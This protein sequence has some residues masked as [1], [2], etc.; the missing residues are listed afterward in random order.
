MRRS[1]PVMIIATLVG[2]LAVLAAPLAA[3]EQSVVEPTWIVDTDY[4]TDGVTQLDDVYSEAQV[5][6]PS[7]RAY[8]LADRIGGSDLVSLIRFT[9]AGELD[10][11]FGEGGFVDLPIVGPLDHLSMALQRT[12]AGNRL[13]L[14]EWSVFGTASFFRYW[15]DGRLDQSF[16]L[17]GA[18]RIDLGRDMYIRDLTINDDG[19]II[20]AGE[21]PARPATYYPCILALTADGARDGTFDS[22]GFRVWKDAG[23]RTFVRSVLM[24]PD[25]SRIYLG[26]RAD[27]D[28]SWFIGALHAN[29][30]PDPYFG[31][32]GIV[33]LQPK[34]ADPSG[35]ITQLHLESSGRL[36]AAGGHCTHAGFARVTSDGQIDPEYGDDGWVTLD[37]G[38]TRPATVLDPTAETVYWLH[39]GDDDL[40]LGGVRSDG[41]F[42][43][44][45]GPTFELVIDLEPGV[46]SIFDL[47]LVR[48]RVGRL[49]PKG[50]Y[51]DDVD[52]S[53][54][55][56]SRAVQVGGG[57]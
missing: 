49:Y 34:C 16:G 43:P 37:H 22:D 3:A 29:G 46:P 33:R 52:F 31:G 11:G 47:G 2:S 45:F 54:L 44:A 53:G 36:V 50:W 7:G 51:R 5:V 28:A 17:G 15:K 26:G 55:I 30:K 57:D 23:R 41:S 38:D 9:A 48:D 14:S 25:G 18:A 4:G 20:T 12:S 1:R 21:C 13:V 42:D 40:H 6:L 24:T 32:D 19:S 56:L 8:F 27:R 35:E 10:Q 39:N